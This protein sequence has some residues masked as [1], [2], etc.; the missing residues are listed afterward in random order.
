MGA[1]TK[2]EDGKE[3]REEEKKN[4]EIFFLFALSLFQTGAWLLRH[5]NTHH[6]VLPDTE[7]RWW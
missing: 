7:F 2:K 3:A 6:C 5:T 4:E 1:E